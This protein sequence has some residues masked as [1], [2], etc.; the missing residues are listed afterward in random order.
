MPHPPNVMGTWSIDN[1][2][3]NY[4]TGRPQGSR[5]TWAQIFKGPAEPVGPRAPRSPGSLERRRPWR[6]SPGGRPP[7]PESSPPS[8]L[9]SAAS[10][11]M[12]RTPVGPI[13]PRW[14]DGL[15]GSDRSTPAGSLPAQRESHA[16]PL[17]PASFGVEPDRQTGVHDLLDGRPV[18]RHEGDIDRL[19][20]VLHPDRR[21]AVLDPHQ[22][23]GP[24]VR[25]TVQ[26][27]GDLRSPT[28]NPGHGRASGTGQDADRQEE[29]GVG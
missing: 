5:R 24:L 25:R 20:V 15:S 8:P 10:N 12:P 19:P 4:R 7:R 1:S 13:R 28:R 26:N 27:D 21:K 3:R 18:V 29:D 16:K 23:S 2:R 11:P 17:L 6:S 9:A 22:P 14:R